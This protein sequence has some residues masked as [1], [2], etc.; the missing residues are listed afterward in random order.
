MNSHIPRSSSAQLSLLARA[1]LVII[2]LLPI[3]VAVAIT[4]AHKGPKKSGL[5]Q[6]PG[7]PV[8]SLLPKTQSDMP[9]AELIR[10]RPSLDL[11]E[12][13][14]R[15]SPEDDL[16][17]TVP[18]PRP[19][20]EEEF[21]GDIEERRNW[22]LFQRQF[23]FNEI[24]VDARA[25]AWE[26][27]PME[28]HPFEFGAEG[29][30]VP[31]QSIGPTP[32]N[33]FFPGSWGKTSGRINTI[34]ISPTNPNIVLIGGA[35]GGV[36]RSVDG[37]TTFTAVT[38]SQ[39]DLAVGSIAFAPS[40]SSIVYAGMGDKDGNYLGTGVLRSTDAGQTWTRV[41]NSTLPPLGV[42][43]Q[44]L[45]DPSN[46][47]RVYV[48]QYAFQQGASFFGSGFYL[49]IDGGVSWTRTF[50]GT[51]K[52]LVRHPT[53][54]S[55]LYLAV[56][57]DFASGGGVFKS[58]NSGQTW[59]RIYTSPFGIP[60]NIKI[61]VTPAAPE[62]V[63]VLNGKATAR[64]E[65]STNGGSTWTNRGGNFDTKQFNYNCYLFV[66]PT[67]PNTVYV[68][69][70]DLWRSTN[71]GSTYANITGNFP[72]LAD[73][74]Q[75]SPGGAKAHPD[76]H[77]FYISPT[78]PSTIYIANDGGIWKSTDGASS[79]TSLNST[80]TLTM[81]TSYDMHPTDASRSYGGTQDN[82]TQKRTGAQTWR[83]FSTGD[84][85]QTF[86]DT[87]DPS[88]VYVTYIGHAVYRYTSNG[89]SFS[90]TIGSSAVFNGDRVAFYPPF[91]GNETN[92]NLYFGTYRLYVSTNRGTSW[93]MP[94]AFTDLTVGGGDVLSAIAVAKS[95]TNVIYT[96]S[97]QGRLMV[98]T[99]GG[100]N[101]TDR[102]S[103]LPQRFIKSITISATDSNT[104]Y[105]TVSGFVTGHVFKTINAGASWT[106][107]SGNLPDIP[108]NDLLIDPRAGNANTLYVGTDVGV[109]RSTVGG[110]TWETFNNGL[111]PTII[112]ELDAQPTGIIQV[113]TYGRGAFEMN[114]NQTT[115][116]TIQFNSA[117]FSVNENAGTA[118]ITVTRGGS[119]SGAVSANY[120][121]A[122]GTATAG[123]DYV[124]SSGTVSFVSGETSKTFNVSI[125]D[126]GALEGNET[127]NLSLSN[128][129]GGAT[130]GSPNTAVLT[131]IDNE[132]SC[133][134]TLN[135]TSQSFGSAGGSSSFTITT[136]PGCSWS[137]VSNAGFITTTSSGSGNG[138][139]N[140]TVGSNSGSARSGTI[141]VGG[142]T[143]TVT[144]SGSGG[145]CP[146]TA[147][148]AGQTINGTLT[149]SDCFFTGSTHYVDVY[150]FNGTAGQ[151]ISINM[152]SGTFD[153]YLYLI[154]SSNQTLAEN[155]DGGGGTNS[156]IPAF[157][158][159]FTLPATATYTIYATS[160]S[161]DG[162]TGSTGSYTLSLSSASCSYS[163]NPTSQSFGASGGNSSFSVSTV[164]GCA[165]TAVSNSSWITTSSTGTGNGTVNYT[166]A[167][168]NSVARTGSI[169]VN[170]QTFSVSQSAGGGGCPASA[171]TVGQTING[172]IT[173]SD[174]FFIGTSRYVDVYTFSGTAGQQIA[175]TMNGSFDTYLY[176]LNAGNQVIAEDDDGAGGTNSRVPAVS[177][178]VTLPATGT[179]TIYATSFSFDGINGG[180]GS[181]SISL[182]SATNCTFSLGQTSQSFGAA[183][184]SSSFTVTAGTGCAWSAISNAT[185]ITTNST[186]SGT[187]TVNF[188][189]ASNPGSAR[190]G[191]ITINNQ[192]FTVNQSAASGCPAATITAGQTISSTL[193]SL[194]CFFTGTTRFVDVY[195]FS[196]T[197]GQQV[198]L[199]MT[200]A[201][202]DTYLYLLNS[203]N[204]T[205]A[206]DDDG[207]GG[208]NSRI[209]FFSGTFTLPATGTYTIYATSYSFDGFTG[210][211]GSYSI[212]LSSGA[213]ASSVQ[214][215][216]PLYT[217]SEASGS[218]TITVTRSG[219][220]SGSASVNYFTGDTAGLQSCTLVNGRASER[221]DYVTSVGTLRF[222]AGETS[223][224]FTVPFI[225][226]VHVEGSETF[227]VALAG[228]SGTS[229]G[230]TAT[231]TVSI[232][233]N[234][235]AV[236][237]SNPI[238]GV[239]FFIRQ[240]Y[241]DIL[242]R[243]PDSTG[244][245]NWINTLAPCPNG[246]FG[247]PPASD[248]D[249]LK[250]AAGF[251]QSD[252]FLNRGY[253]AFRFYM[254]SQNQRPT[255]A[256]FIPDMA[257][258]GG[259]K[260]PA[261]EEASKVTF[262]EAFVQR[263]EFL[264]R[265]GG[266]SGQPLANALLQ[267][268]G[269]PSNTFTVTANMTNGQILRGI[270]E[271]SAT[272]NKFL[273]DGTVSIQYFG[274]LRRDPDAIGYQNN[275]NTLNANPS[276]LRHMIFI[277]IY[278][279]EYR[280]RFGSQ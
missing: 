236:A 100:V 211:T 222:A 249:R 183:G 2:L 26:S 273:T 263:P 275:V 164:T 45:V 14:T 54:A 240:Q 201:T 10:E 74:N 125:V 119:S 239:D 233:D 3:A 27:R 142:Q 52:D 269:L 190:S 194:D 55:T 65:V 110:T 195:N 1:R 109:F 61:A 13:L 184:G 158:G 19:Q 86:V 153:T 64:V 152:T 170:G 70:R 133:S 53:Q 49:S 245:Q 187:G 205:I 44:V 232:A 166:V 207:G 11:V 96:G 156:R 71:G 191:T 192:T 274:F 76:Q 199:N 20:T 248:C 69:T 127:I 89:D 185:W 230:S 149:T 244:L 279:V 98:S 265:Y 238:D 120:S 80:L 135:P 130:L 73:P 40:N 115:S 28:K 227:T 241:L 32:T 165:W 138:T 66:H 169:T 209:P 129:T 58:T 177:G 151:Q 9:L 188:I 146:S 204:Q 93:T 162:I 143:F 29:V 253:W 160:F 5:A 217:A 33:S 30:E 256:Q 246:G 22:F 254:V 243:Q 180:F 12:T 126:D 161:S 226:D 78:S 90:G 77:H 223:K 16:L 155:D 178:F 94:S 250:V 141:T 150:T 252:E 260:S 267:T 101:W 18:I 145:G 97:S 85:G 99:N 278:S 231:A 242:N 229:L 213:I 83:E 108:T 234:D 259:P 107:I 261:E 121:L 81:F 117:T 172:N 91:V 193:T 225:D 197:A 268:A 218:I 88:I 4:T 84:G 63:Y 6:P 122:N 277:F 37:G 214:F 198:A 212:S 179:Y 123:Q 116:P 224:T 51:A 60:D 75:Y 247:E 215:S 42:I 41:S 35:T 163:L 206:E 17:A 144:Q 68:G 47:N 87:L 173:T 196:G 147:I 15:R 67:D 176:L 72:N 228:A 264:A 39:V 46:P 262:A 128:P 56:Q 137:A 43:S 95:N 21:E 92:S 8:Q 25:I 181:Y 257:Q 237:S 157:S 235:L 131:I 167:A 114:L 118:T 159:F 270:V 220:T 136:G 24:P 36:W 112:S 210:G 266:L 258:V 59:Q 23:P 154:N 140:Y 251:F 219:D 175:I 186:G 34:A 124:A 132:S 208:T 221:C 104:A 216:S 102:T 134:F 148:A 200:S 203:S 62:N 182:L 202:F 79:F 168:N 103:G 50:T 111:P 174:C 271:T 113:G 31:W 106:N 139:V 171:I 38:D 189:V 105:V 276:N 48:A 82:G 57:N 7:V 280:S 255:Y 272:L